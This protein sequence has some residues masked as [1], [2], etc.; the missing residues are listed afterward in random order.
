MEVYKCGLLKEGE[1]VKEIEKSLGKDVEKGYVGWKD[2][3][4]FM[5]VKGI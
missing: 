5:I 3:G 2:S 4:D 1:K